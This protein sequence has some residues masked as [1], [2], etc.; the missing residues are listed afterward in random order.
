MQQNDRSLCPR[1]TTT[2]LVLFSLLCLFC[3]SPCDH[4][5][6]F[7]SPATLFA[8]R[9]V[10]QRCYP[11]RQLRR[12]VLMK[13]WILRSDGTLA[14]RAAGAHQGSVPLAMTEPIRVGLFFLLVRVLLFP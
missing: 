1:Q 11:P 8:K 12:F 3:V 2:H 9:E 7:L 14:L 10:A 4:Y 13:P 6:I 5:G